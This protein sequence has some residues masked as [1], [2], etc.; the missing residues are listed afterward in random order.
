MNSSVETILKLFGTF[1]DSPRSP[2]VKSRSLKLL[3]SD[4]ESELFF[5]PKNNKIW[6]I[7]VFVDFLRKWGE[8]N[9]FE[10]KLF[11]RPGGE[12]PISAERGRASGQ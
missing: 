9:D 7:F 10:S 1:L 11:L 5:R 6:A 2:R 4:F 12:G 3:F 8:R